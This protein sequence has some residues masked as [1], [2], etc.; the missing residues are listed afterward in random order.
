MKVSSQLDKIALQLC[1]LACD[2]M[3]CF[4]CSSMVQTPKA[5]CWV[6]VHMQHLP[7]PFIIKY[8]SLS[9]STIDQ[10]LKWFAIDGNPFKPIN[11]CNKG[12]PWI[13]NLQDISVWC[14]SNWWLS[15]VTAGSPRHWGFTIH[16]LACPEACWCRQENSPICELP[17]ETEL[18]AR[19]CH[20]QC[21]EIC[22]EFDMQKLRIPLWYQ[23]EDKIMEFQECFKRRC[24]Y[25][26]K[27]S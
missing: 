21:P 25:P 4:C 27:S 2:S 6:V 13:L 10:I 12:C 8:T 18:M 11:K 24:T 26:Q 5:L 19:A 7:I 1:P 9:Q 3:S 14:T 23:R 22:N 15:T 17:T 20:Y 16:Y